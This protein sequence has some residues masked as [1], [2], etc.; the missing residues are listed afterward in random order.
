[1]QNPSS[2]PNLDDLAKHIE[3]YV[4]A[5]PDKFKNGMDPTLVPGIKAVPQPM[6]FRCA[7]CQKPVLSGSEA[8]TYCGKPT[9]QTF[10]GGDMVKERYLIEDL[11]VKRGGFGTIYAVVDKETQKR[12]VMKQLQHRRQITPKNRELFKREGEILSTLHHPG[13]PAYHDA[14]ELDG[15]LYLV[16]ER[17][18]G[19][20]VSTILRERG[21]FSEAEALDFFTQALDVFE[22]LGGH[23]P[24]ILHRDVK[25]GNFMKTMDG[26]YMLLDFGNATQWRTRKSDEKVDM[27]PPREFTSVWTKGYAAPEVLMGMVAYPSSDLFG[28]AATMLNLVSNQHPLGLYEARTGTFNFPENTC[29]PQLQ[30][31]LSRMLALKVEDRYRNAAEVRA[32]LKDAKLIS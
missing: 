3:N 11:L 29:S 32:A 16:I 10:K 1:M 23:T 28:L 27:G 26:R 4:K 8:C 2:N 22:Y 31:I 24:P 25:P 19:L 17:I 7:F 18:D 30:A 6:I 21:K 14:F 20:T 9:E 12:L 5:N 13:I 15:A